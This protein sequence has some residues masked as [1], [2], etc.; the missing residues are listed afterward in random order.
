MKKNYVAQADEKYYFETYGSEEEISENNFY[1]P[2]EED[3]VSA[4]EVYYEES[5]VEEWDV[6]EEKP[7][8]WENIR[9]KKEREGDDYKPAKRVIP[10]GQIQNLGKRHKSQKR[11]QKLLMN[12]KTQRRDKYL[13]T[14][15]EVFI[16]KME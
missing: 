7:G 2:E 10:T 5:E 9:K 13:N 1:I 11:N 16:K 12:T 3:Y 6:S 8:L 14:P 4:E 15:D